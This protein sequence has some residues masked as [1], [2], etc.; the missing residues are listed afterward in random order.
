MRCNLK[1]FSA[2]L[3]LSAIFSFSLIAYSC[4][5]CFCFCLDIVG[6]QCRNILSGQADRRKL[7]RYA[8]DYPERA[9][10]VSDTS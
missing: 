1:G 4:R 5:F 8:F 9:S 10:E 7:A 2:R 3:D 6:H